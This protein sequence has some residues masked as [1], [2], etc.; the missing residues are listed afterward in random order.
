MLVF[1][2]VYFY[3]QDYFR[4]QTDTRPHTH[5]HAHTQAG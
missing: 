3:M 1:L 2:F 4:R 5:M